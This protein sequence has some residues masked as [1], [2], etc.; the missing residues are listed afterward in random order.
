M[1]IEQYF[2]MTDYSLKEVILNGDSPVPTIVVDGVVQPVSHRK[3]HFARECRSPKDSRRS[4]A[5]KPQRRTAPVK[6]STSNALVS[7]CDGIRCYDW[8]YLI[9]EEPANFALMAITSSSSSSDN[10][11]TSCSK[12]CSKAYAQLHS[13]YD[14][15]TDDFCKS[16]FVVLSY[17]AGSNPV[18]D[19]MMFLHQLQEL[20]CHQNLILVFHTAPIAIETDHSAFTVQLSPTKPAQD[21]SHTNETSAPI[22]EDWV[23]DSEDESETNDPQIIPSFL[24]SSEQVTT[25]MSVDHLIKDCDYHAKKKTQ[26]T[27][28]NYAHGVL[29]QSKPVSITAARPVCAAV[30]KIMVTR[31]RHAHSIDTKSKSPIRRHITCSPSPKTSISPP[32]VT[33]AQAP[34]V[35]VAKGKKGKWGNPQYALKDKGVIDS[36]CSRH[37]TM[38]MSYLSIEEHNGGYVSFGGNLKGGK[39][40]GKGNIKKNRVLVTKPHNKTPYELLHG[41]TP[42]IGFMRPFGCPVT[43]LNTLDPLGKFKGKVDEVFL[44]GYFVN[45]KAFRVFSSRT[46]IVQ[47]TLH[48]NF[49]ENKPN[50]AGSGLT[51]LFDI[52]SLTRTMNYQ[53][54]TA[55]N[56]SNPSVGFQDKIDAEK[57]GEEVTQQY[58]LFPVWS[59]G[60][61]NP[62]DKDGDAAFDGK[63]HEVDTKKPESVVNVSPS[64]SAQSGKQDAKTKKKA[65]GKSSVE[66]FIENRDLSV[67]F[68]DHSDNNNAFQLPDNLDMLVMEDI[69]YS[70]HENVGAEA[71]F[72]N[73]ETSITVSPIPTTRTQKDHPVSQIIGDLSSTTQTRSM[74]RVIKDQGGLSQIFNDDFH[75]CMFACFLSQEEPKRDER[76]IVVRN[77]AR[78]VAQGHTQEEG[79]DYE[80]VFAPVARIEAISQDKYVAEILKKFG[81]TERKLASTPIDTEKPLL[82]DPDGG[83]VDVHIYRLISWQCKK[84]TVVA[85][86]STDAEYVA[87]ASC[88]AQVLWIQNQL[89]DYG[90]IKYALTINP[91]IYVSC[92]KQFWNTVVVKQSNDVTRL[93]ALVDRKKV[94]VTEAVIRDVLRL[95]DADGVNCLPNEEI[96]VELARMGYEKP[97]TKLLFY[98]AF[99]SSQWK[100]LIH[101]IL[102]SMSTERT[103]WNKFSSTM[104]S[105]VICLSIGR[106]FNFSKYI[107]ESL[108]RNVDSSSKFYMYP[109]FIQLII[110]NQL[111]DLSTHATKYTSPTLTQKVFTNMRRVGKGF[112]GVEMPLFEGM[113]VARK[114][115]EQGDA[116]EQVQDNVDDAAQGADTIVLG[117]DE[118]LDACAA[119]TRRVEH[120]EHDKVAQTLE[121]IKLKKRVKKLERANKGRMIADLDRDTGAALMDDEGTEKKAKYAQV[122]GDEQVKGRQ[123]EIYQI[124]MDHASKVLSMQEDEPEVQEAV[125]VV[126]TAKLITE[127]VAAVSELVN[128][129][130]ATIAAIPTATITAAPIGLLQGMSYD[131]IRPIFEAKFNSNMEF[132]L[133]TKEQMEEEENRAIES[134]NETS[135][136]KA[137]KRRKLKILNNIWRLCLIKM[138]MCIQRLLHLLEREDLE[139]LWSIVKER[140]STL[141][142]NNFSDDCLLTTLRAMFKRPDGQDQVWKSQRSIHGQAMAKSWKLLESCGVHIISFT[143]TQLILLVE[144]RYPLLRFTLDQMLNA[145]RLRMEEESEMSLKLL[146]FEVDAAMDLEEKTLSSGPT[147]LFDIDSL[148]RTINYPPVTAENQ[149]NPSVGFQDNFDAEKAREEVTQQYMLF[150]VWSSGSLNPQNK[151]GDATFDGIEHEVNTKKPE[152]A[153]NVSLSSSAQSGK[154]DDKTKKKAKGKSSME[155]ITYSDHE[156]VGVEANFNN[157]ETS[158]TV[159]P[160]PTTRTHKDHLVSQNIGD[161]S[162]TTQT[163]SMT[164]V[165]KDQGGLSQIFNDDFHTCM[166]ACFLSQ[167]EPKRIHQAVKD[168]NWIE[169]MQE[170]LLQFKMQKVWI[171]VDLPH[172]KRANG[173]KWVYRNKKDE[174]GIVV[175]NKARRVA[176]GHTQEEGIDYEEV[177]A[178]VARI[179]AIRLFL[180]YASFIGFMV[181]Q[182]DV[183]NAF[184]YGTIKEDVYVCQPLGFEDPDHPDKVYKVV[185]ALYGLHQALRAWYETLANYLLENDFHKGKIDQTLFLKK[186]KRDILLVQIYVDDIIFGAINKYLC[187]SFKKL[188]KDKFQM[189]SMG[190][191]TFFLG[192]QVK[193]KKDGIF[194]IQ[195]KYVA[196]I[197]KKTKGKSASTPIDTEKPL[198][199]DPDGED[200]DV[201]IYRSM[202]SS[203]MYLTSSRPNII[204]ASN[205][206]TRLQ[207]LVDKKKVVITEVVI[208]DVLRLDDADGVDC[209]PN[210]EI[211][212]KLAL[213]GYEKPSTKLT[214]YKDFFL[215]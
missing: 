71:D 81:L 49:V 42:S 77:K 143:T 99:F 109:R 207:A 102:Q 206:V 110:Q 153:V 166:F 13:Q 115:E 95:D 151:D 117:D 50:I 128:A 192:L 179:E 52:D 141:K 106:K 108:V 152:F 85:T 139:S 191:L 156:N 154:Q 55:G 3:G 150:P 30:P 189:S 46:R 127:V 23:F 134:I 53:P 132:L 5:T 45:S 100:F 169:A 209:L 92:I 83:D 201:N 65:K 142:P 208:R 7:Q 159:S 196:E 64:S 146:S 122:A 18:V 88:C 57:A 9:E 129:A 84:Q 96:F 14:K 178:Q 41:R 103:S 67:E 82:K 22:I 160:I 107:F 124:D 123:A 101:T 148:I 104:A 93:Q 214:F 72:N 188:M 186:Q 2:L 89:L 176:Q 205:D 37:M 38:N 184:L 131:D 210:E 68:E 200:V 157:L 20:S 138:T 61:L 185:K 187:K 86:S 120:L 114:I 59:S 170:E 136:Q 197:L 116:E 34:V 182:M 4:G 26:P 39:I 212:A 11:V 202:I 17:Q 164:R 28:R 33:A 29:T 130:S 194:I 54:V 119:L 121:I 198:L 10:E 172:G 80:E 161:L 167:E 199:K 211:F 43:I 69:T 171:L 66:S 145:V 44:V 62:Q 135:A 144:R 203:L 98:K 112:S 215:S 1:Q 177:F 181:Y 97:S 133:K 31:P 91:T 111:G 173:T 94:V 126:T 213:M 15:L 25:P 149:S 168:P 35:S 74:T 90:Y 47:E 75:T 162:S 12:A 78:L 40:F 58:M 118:A 21:L 19:I 175:T 79:I 87:A 63:E 51:W 183:K 32:R 180:A 24:Q 193:Q 147:W 204:F 140:F 73:L 125:D 16:Q 8:S 158:I 190:E 27:P 56:Q 174:R 70:D 6:N 163:R 76:D 60:S 48:V 36:R 137:A 165:I 113:L 105:A 195:D 155:D